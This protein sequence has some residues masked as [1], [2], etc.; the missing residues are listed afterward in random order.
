MEGFSAGTLAGAGSFR[1]EECGFPVALHELDEVPACP[2][3]AG[4]LFRRSSMFESEITPPPSTSGETP[5]WVADT[6]DGLVTE[7]AYLAFEAP[8]GGVKVVGLQEGW[9]R[10]GR[11]IS[12]DVRFDD[13]TVSR[14]HALI[15]SDS[16]GAKALDDRSLNGL[17]VNGE[18][19]DMRDLE[20]GD[21]LGVG[22][23]R[24]FFLAVAGDRNGDPVDANAGVR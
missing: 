18:K 9:T 14:R 23:F 1:C 5:R 22:R 10:I 24:I 2:R 20:N 6:R 12:A 3:C 19:V 13:T 7:G 8:G 17:F 21:E 4:R 11:S 15:H 16:T